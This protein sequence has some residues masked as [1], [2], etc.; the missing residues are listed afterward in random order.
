MG[1]LGGAQ[2]YLYWANRRV[3]QWLEDT[4]ASIPER[5]LWKLKTPHFGVLPTIEVT[6]GK[7]RT[8]KAD[9]AD[10][11]QRT[12]GQRIVSDLSSPVPIEFAKGV[13]RVTFG[14]FVSD[15]IPER[16]LIYTAVPLGKENSQ[17][18]VAVCLFGSLENYADFVIEA[19]TQRGYGCWTSSA[20][21]DV[22]HFLRGREPEDMVI[23]RSKED[24]ARE[25]VVV[26]CNQGE[27]GPY[28]DSRKGYNRKFTYGET[29]EVSEW[30]AEIY[31][32]VDLSDNPENGHSRVLIGAPLWVR[33][34]NLR[35]ILLY[36][37]YTRAELEMADSENTTI[38]RPPF[39]ERVK[40]AIRVL[41]GTEI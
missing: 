11:F 21:P 13:G 27:T 10:I 9:L 7:G 2:K 22:L 32:D 36:S 14:E 19:G 17:A 1:E 5:P 25:A 30:C 18:S 12:F 20:A 39:N 15:G 31:L 28:S 6:S 33:T 8:T 41:R 38:G 35:S 3:F 23:C 37:D 26:C 4:N 24:F 16:A 34:P 40:R 29:R